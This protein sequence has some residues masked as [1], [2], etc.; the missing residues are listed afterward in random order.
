MVVDEVMAVKTTCIPNCERAE[1]TSKPT[2]PSD[3]PPPRPHLLNFPI[4]FTNRDQTFT[5]GE[6]GISFKAPQFGLERCLRLR[7]LIA[8]AKDPA[9]TWWLTKVSCFRGS[10]DLFW[11]P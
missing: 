1:S 11:Q 10:N 9:F 6:G 2:P 3:T 8:L 4:Q 7:A 5:L